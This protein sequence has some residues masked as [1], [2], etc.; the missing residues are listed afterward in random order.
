ML[1]WRYR[2]VVIL[3]NE[4]ISYSKSFELIQKY[5]FKNI[6]DKKKFDILSK[7]SVKMS[8]SC[9]GIMTS[10]AISPVNRYRLKMIN[11]QHEIIWH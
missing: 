3:Q 8:T 2:Q 11:N 7:F 1:E 9:S 6:K 4:Y 10:Q 5:M